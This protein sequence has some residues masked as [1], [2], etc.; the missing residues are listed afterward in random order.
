[1]DGL[2]S[3]FFMYNV[4]PG[5]PDFFYVLRGAFFFFFLSYSFA[6]VVLVRITGKHLFCYFVSSSVSQWTGNGSG[7]QM[8]VRRVEKNVGYARSHM[9]LLFR[10]EIS[11]I[12]MKWMLI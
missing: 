3:C 6:F 4:R 7:A 5:L 1:M 9:P 2:S 10:Y 8:A 11:T 12:V